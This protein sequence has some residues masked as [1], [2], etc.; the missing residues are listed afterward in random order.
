MQ[1]RRLCKGAATSEAGLV[2]AGHP[3]AMQSQPLQG[4][5]ISL[6]QG[7]DAP[8]ISESLGKERNKQTKPEKPNPNPILR[9]LLGQCWALP[10]VQPLLCI[11]SLSSPECFN[12]QLSSRHVSHIL[13][14]F[15]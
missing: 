11:A 15:K 14:G 5:P 1:T 8:S 9:T 6:P 3:A 7:T 10:T 4:E 2:P 13:Q 12:S